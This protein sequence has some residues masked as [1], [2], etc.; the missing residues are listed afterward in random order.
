MSLEYEVPDPQNPSHKGKTFVLHISTLDVDALR[1]TYHLARVD[2]EQIEVL[3]GS[4]EKHR[5]ALEKHSIGT[6]HKSDGS[7]GSAEM[8]AWTLYNDSVGSLSQKI[9]DMKLEV[10]NIR[11][12]CYGRLVDILGFY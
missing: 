11:C 7:N 2:E 1:A 6:A 4:I 8:A 9:Y 3:R 10:G 12:S 5:L